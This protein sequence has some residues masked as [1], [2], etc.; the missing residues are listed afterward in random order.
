[1]FR[2][3]LAVAVALMLV[4]GGLYAEDIKGEFVKVDGGKVTIKHDGKETSHK[5]ADVKVKVGKDAK[6][7]ALSEALGKWKEGQKGTFTVEK[8][9]VTKAQKER[10]K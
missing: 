9:E 6:E 5:I 7:V 10:K 2:K 8:D 4:V 1:M 3:L